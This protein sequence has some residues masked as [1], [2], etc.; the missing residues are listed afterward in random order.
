MRFINTTGNTVTLSDINKSIP[1]IG[2]NEQE[3]DTDDV[4][5]SKA[6]Q[7]LVI[8]G[9]FIVTQVGNRRIEKNLLRSQEEREADPG[10]PK[11]TIDVM[12]KGHFTN[13]TGYSKANRNLVYALNRVGVRVGI[14]FIKEEGN[15]LDEFELARICRFRRSLD[16][17]INIHSAIPTFAQKY[18]GYSILN[19][20]IEAAT[21]P[22]QFIEACDSY[23]EIWVASDFSRQVLLQAGV[24]KPIFVIPNCVDPRIYNTR[25]KPIKFQPEVKPYVFVSVF[26]W[27][28][29]KGYDALLKAY[30]R[31]FT[32][33]DPV[34]LLIVTKYNF[35]G[36]HRRLFDVDATIR[37]YRSDYENAAS[38][39][40]CGQDI[41][42]MEMPRL[43]KSCNCFVLPSRGEGFGLPYVEAG[44]CGLP[45]IATKHSG[46]TM[47]LNEDNSYL[48]DID[49]LSA[50]PAGYTNV[51]FWDNEIFPELSDDKTVESL[52]KL[53]RRAFENRAEAQAK[54]AKLQKDLNLF[55]LDVVGSLAKAR[56]EEICKMLNN[57]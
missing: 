52:G 32:N 25:A 22:A 30:L 42:E 38:V 33:D 7:T 44:L 8:N 20:T 6:F 15:S 37:S 11:P 39:V 21:V 48:L 17:A 31:E 16:C 47:F 13:N 1:F 36:Y 49:R 12:I 28:Y 14:D 18:D 23:N 46:H 5:K 50:V 3:I 51:H 41:H 54:T 34:S 27:N 9:H 43:Y 10:A 45:V 53:M 57:H 29:R 2:H 55:T 19:T 4:Q 40:R 26:A 56:L 35:D 24:Q